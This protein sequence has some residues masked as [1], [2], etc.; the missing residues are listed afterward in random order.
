MLEKS[1]RHNSREY[2]NITVPA[3]IIQ[4]NPHMIKLRKPL[5]SVVFLL[6]LLPKKDPQNKTI[7]N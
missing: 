5:L 2:Q 3:N 7:S 1:M 6:H 4:M